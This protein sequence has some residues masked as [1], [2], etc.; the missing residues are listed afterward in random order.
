VSVAESRYPE[1]SHFSTSSHLDRGRSESFLQDCSFRT[2][3][4][5]G[6]LWDPNTRSPWGRS[7]WDRASK[8][9]RSPRIGAFRGV[10]VLVL[11]EQ[12]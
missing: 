6:Y 7:H 12:E 10:L 4:R 5:L 8:M 1:D 9:R 3:K 2:Y 11:V